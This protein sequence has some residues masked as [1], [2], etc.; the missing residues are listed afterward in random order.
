MKR[1]DIELQFY[2]FIDCFQRSKKRQPSDVEELKDFYQS[3]GQVL[4]F[5]MF[6][7][8]KIE[9]VSKEKIRV[10]YSI[11][12]SPAQSNKDIRESFEF[13]W[14]IKD[15]KAELELI[16]SPILKFSSKY[17]E[18]LLERD[19]GDITNHQD[20]GGFFYERN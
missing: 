19:R 6:N 10:E 3:R 2:C 7:F 4:D 12:K 16:A 5:S 8:L 11:K 9:I 17:H 18:S 20:K 15:S 14:P 1:R 13:T